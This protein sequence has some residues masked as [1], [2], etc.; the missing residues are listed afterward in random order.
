M[1]NAMRFVLKPKRSTGKGYNLHRSN[2]A[3]QGLYHGKDVSFG[4]TISH[5]HTRSKKKW[6]P[7]VIEKR[8]FSY[9]LGTYL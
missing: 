9:A 8:V 7:N 4:H 2:K 5:S 3:Q 6:F 1:S